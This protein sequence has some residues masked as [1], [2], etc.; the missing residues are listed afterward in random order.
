MSNEQA[1][2]RTGGDTGMTLRDYFAGQALAGFAA[3][4]NANRLTWL[5]GS[6]ARAAY[7][8][9]DSMLEVRKVKP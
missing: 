9:S 2:P 8:A 6:V 5:D 3:S 4:S 7:A 1:F